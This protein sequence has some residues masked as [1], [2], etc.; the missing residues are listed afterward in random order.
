M[1][2]A[3]L[4][5]LEIG[6]T[7]CAIIFGALTLVLALISIFKRSDTEISPQPLI[8]AMEKEFLTRREFST[9]VIRYEGHVK[10]SEEKHAN[11]DRRIREAEKSASVEIEKHIEV[12]RKDVGGLSAHLSAVQAVCT[13]QNK[14]LERIEQNQTDMP[15][16]IVA[17][18]LNAKK[19]TGTI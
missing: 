9:H 3:E 10:N 2:L 6:A 16:K 1:M 5:G 14:Q 13:I 12:V 17:D 11:L 15:G 7:I 4:S 8:V 19:L 18:L